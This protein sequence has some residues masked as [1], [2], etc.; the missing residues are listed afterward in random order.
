MPRRKLG[1]RRGLGW[2]VLV[3]T[4]LL[5]PSLAGAVPPDT[6]KAWQEAPG[7]DGMTG[8][9]NTPTA[10][11]LPSGGLRVGFSWFDKE[12]A[13]YVRGK[14]DNY[15]YFLTF[16]FVPRV[17][18]SVRASYFPDDQLDTATN[19][20]GTVDR[21]GNA[22]VL[23]LTEKEKRPAVAV[24]IDDLRGT[25][26][27]H[28]LYAVASKTF[29]IKPK[30]LRLRLT[31]GYASDVLKADDHI[32]DGGFGGAELGVGHFASWALDYDTEK[33]N[34]SVR[35]FAFRRVTAHLALLNF[36]GLAGGVSWT[37]QF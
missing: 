16:G 34:T 28:S 4:G 11:V 22:R 24:G 2:V 7:L 10:D 17:E 14:S 1:V 35:L 18:V 30:L 15:H 37:H 5:L 23:V 6:L 20:K 8:L 25:R 13:Y 32:L 27:F 29:T 12:W 36:E 26:R 19:Q 21:G 31:G 33:W 3:L 9:I